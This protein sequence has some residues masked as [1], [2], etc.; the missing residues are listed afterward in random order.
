MDGGLAH[1]SIVAGGFRPTAK[2]G[3]LDAF[4]RD[5]VSAPETIFDSQQIVDS[6]PLFWDDAAISGGGTASTF[7]T[8]KAASL[9]SHYGHDRAALRRAELEGKP[10][11][12]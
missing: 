2:N 10:V 12:A 3:Y 11:R 8:D 1:A 4:G 6:Q 5:R 7:L 9:C